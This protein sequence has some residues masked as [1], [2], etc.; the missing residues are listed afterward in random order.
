MSV[1]GRRCAKNGILKSWTKPW[2]AR[3]KQCYHGS[4]P[5]VLHMRSSTTQ[6]QRALS[7]DPTVALISVV[8]LGFSVSLASAQQSPPNTPGAPAGD[9]SNIPKPIIDILDKV[10]LRNAPNNVGEQ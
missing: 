8:V 4:P 7:T 3:S 2:W 10:A 1:L 5:G 6:W 9:V